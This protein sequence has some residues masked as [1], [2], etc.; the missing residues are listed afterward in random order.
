LLLSAKK[1]DI[2]TTDKTFLHHLISNFFEFSSSLLLEYGSL[3]C[4]Y[5][6]VAQT[7]F[8]YCNLAVIPCKSFDSSVMCSGTPSCQ[9]QCD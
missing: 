7:F 1:K 4:F 2:I 6:R 5:E 8:K 9:I 3:S